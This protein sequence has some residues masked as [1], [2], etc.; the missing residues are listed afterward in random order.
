[1]SLKGLNTQNRLT[2]VSMK[3]FNYFCKF[4]LN[5][6][7]NF[8]YKDIKIIIGPKALEF[9]THKLEQ[10][11]WISSSETKSSYMDKFILIR[12]CKKRI[13]Y[14]LEFLDAYALKSLDLTKISEEGHKVTI[15]SILR[16]KPKPCEN[17]Q[18]VPLNHRYIGAL[19]LSLLNLQGLHTSGDSTSAFKTLNIS[20][21]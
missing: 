15:Q 14:F 8:L 17:K 16:P 2:G 5:T 1:M 3:F 10:L 13:N 6:S 20:K 9:E 18:I 12:E 4:G 19:L 11:R 21:N 7:G